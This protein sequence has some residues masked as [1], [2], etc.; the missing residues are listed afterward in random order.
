M[1]HAIWSLSSLE[2]ESRM[3]ILLSLFLIFSLCLLF[4]EILINACSVTGVCC[5]TELA[6]WV[7]AFASF[8]KCF[9]V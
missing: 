8:A 4:F 2:M 5:L 9:A 7:K 6:F 3:K 1:C